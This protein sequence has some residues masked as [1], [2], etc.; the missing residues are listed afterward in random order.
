MSPVRHG[1]KG[2]RTD[3]SVSCV[4]KIDALTLLE[5]DTFWAMHTPSWHL[6]DISIHIDGAKAADL[7]QD[8]VIRD[9]EYLAERPSSDPVSQ[10]RSLAPK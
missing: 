2:A 7:F 6:A 1:K 5:F 8:T 4:L 9:G 10:N 3:A